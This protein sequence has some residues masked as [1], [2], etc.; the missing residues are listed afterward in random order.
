MALEN[1]QTIALI[2]Y[3][4]IVF[5]AIK[6]VR[7]QFA[8]TKVQHLVFGS[9]AA[10]SVL[11]WFRTGIYPGLE[12]HFLWLT[13]LTLVLGW[14]WA[15]V[16]SAAA[17][18]VTALTGT[19]SWYDIGVIGLISCVIPILFSYFVYAVVYHKLT[20]HFFIYVF[21]CSFFT[22]AA[23]IALKMFIY[24]L[25]YSQMAMYEWHILVDNYLI[26]IPLLL[27]P[28]ALLN[29]MTMTL[30]VVYKPQWVATFYD[31]H[32]LNK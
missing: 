28:E 9:A 19:I 12:I 24:S 13:A 6:P 30:A 26:L 22:G 29:G 15:L 18:L 32:Y 1:Y 21:V 27:F 14:R 11:W 5:F 4:M 23:S 8:E 7:F 17:L 20:R 2:I 3:L 10:L 25:F 31:S 16:S